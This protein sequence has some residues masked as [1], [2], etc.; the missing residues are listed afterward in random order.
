MGYVCV[1]DVYVCMLCEMLGKEVQDLIQ[2]PSCCFGSLIRD[3]I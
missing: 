3:A 2:V 1:W